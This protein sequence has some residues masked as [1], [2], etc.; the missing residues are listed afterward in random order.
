MNPRNLDVTSPR[1]TGNSQTRKIFSGGSP[2]CG[3]GRRSL[4]YDFDRHPHSCTGKLFAEYIR[5]GPPE[6]RSIE[7]VTLVA[8][9]VWRR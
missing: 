9:P 6:T 3:I 4:Q 1:S 2:S 7:I 5:T 8:G